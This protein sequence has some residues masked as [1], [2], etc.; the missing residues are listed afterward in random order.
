MIGIMADS[1][2]NLHSIKLAVRL[3]NEAGCSLIIHAGDFVA[4]FAA[5]ELENLGCPV[6]AVF[7]NC[8][9]EKKGLEK[10]FLSFGEIKKAPL[11]FNHDNLNFMVTHIPVAKRSYPASEKKYIIIFAHTHKPEIRHEK[12]NLLINPGET[13]G[14]VSGKSTVALLDPKTLSVDI[15]TL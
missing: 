15:I 13:G 2:D 6:K 9:G 7:G 3:F 1:H 14:W 11:S 10:A 5:R 4:P 8:D 12:K